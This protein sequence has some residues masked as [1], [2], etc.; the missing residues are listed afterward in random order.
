MNP[1]PSPQK[2]EALPDTF[3]VARQP[4]FDR[5]QNIWGFELLFRRSL[6]DNFAHIT[7]P[8]NA[9]I[10]VCSCGFLCSTKDIDEGLKIS[11]NFTKKLLLDRIPH[12]LPPST[13][14]I[15]ILEDIEI[16]AELKKSLI[17]LKDEGFTL[18]LDDFIGD[19]SYREILDYVDI[20]KVDC[21]D[22]SIEE[23]LS[24]KKN[25]EDS[26][27]IFLAEKV[28]SEAMYLALR[29][30]GFDL[31]QGYYF[32]TPQN[33]QD[34]K[35]NSLVISR[36][37]LTIEIEHKEFDIDK[38]HQIIETDVSLSYRLLLYINSAY[39]SFRRKISSIKQAI[40]LLG[41]KKL[42]HWVR[43]TVCS[44]ILSEETHPELVRLALQRAYLLDEIE[45]LS[46][47]K[48]V[49][50]GS[51]FIVGMFSLLEAMLNTPMKSI[52]NN[53][54]VAKEIQATLLGEDSSL[55]D[56]LALAVALESN[57]LEDAEKLGTKLGV[58]SSTIF[59][60]NQYAI[61]KVDELM[62]QVRGQHSEVPN[63]I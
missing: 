38:V 28:N 25:F 27:C 12:A 9:S 41:M 37:K 46:K 35:L 42:R 10:L 60:A 45:K 3:F 57:L 21:L 26:P 47:P 63:P 14:V 34:K 44:D 1:K 39:F 18:A 48:H 40:T 15:E 32:A 22:R 7:D 50:R 53:L 52:V 36:L 58:S 49:L 6:E 5:K 2:T 19:E 13:T 16:T 56:Y 11:I 54:P 59:C 4:I 55:S 43:L 31:F 33:L 61:M 20:I 8:D 24:I 17:E 30:C 23:V 29:D 51:L 62:R